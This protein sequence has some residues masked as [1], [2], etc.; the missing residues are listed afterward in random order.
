M[1]KNTGGGGNAK[2]QARKFQG[3]N[4][5]SDLRKSEDI[6]EKYAIVDI[7]YGNGLNVYTNDGQEI[8]CRIP[9]KFKGR[10]KRNNFIEKGAWVLIGIYEWEK[11]EKPKSCELLHIYDRNEIEQLFELPGVNLKTLVAKSRTECTAAAESDNEI[12]EEDDNDAFGFKFTDKIVDNQ[13]M[14]ANDITN[15]A[16]VSFNEEV[17]IEDL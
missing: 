17:S 2:R 12:E 16:V 8:W 7:I 1:V 9:G 5:S 4:K 15:V 6:S 3:K 10:N 13:T 11:T 14:F